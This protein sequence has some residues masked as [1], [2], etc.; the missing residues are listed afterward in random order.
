MSNFQL[1]AEIPALFI[2]TTLVL[3]LLVG[4]FLNVVIYRVPVMLNR[5]WRAQCA[6]LAAEDEGRV[7]AVGAA[8]EAAA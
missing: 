8:A 2:G 3:G 4:S 5:D 1:F 6:E 7:P